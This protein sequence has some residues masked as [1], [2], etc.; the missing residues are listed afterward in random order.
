MLRRVKVGIAV[1]LAL[2]LSALSGAAVAVNGFTDVSPAST[3]AEGIAWANETGLMRGFGDGS[4]RPS[5]P[6]ERGQFAST[7]QSYHSQLQPSGEPG[8][9]GP[10]GDQGPAGPTGP[11][12]PAGEM[13]P[14]Y[15]PFL[16]GVGRTLQ[17]IAPEPSQALSTDWQDTSLR[18]NE[19]PIVGTTSGDF[20]LLVDVAA[21][22]TA[23]GP[24]GNEQDFDTEICVRLYNRSE[25]TH[26]P[27]S[28]VCHDG[29]DT[30]FMESEPFSITGD[31]DIFSL[32]FQGS[33]TPPLEG[34]VRLGTV[35]RGLVFFEPSN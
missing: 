35:S 33:G 20:R 25:Q 24:T 29:R 19:L 5:E 18:P 31:R 14:L 3:H 32:Q 17:A 28:E 11:A 12:G 1:T 2:A 16:Q 30:A 23:F 7:L 22:G 10:A 21:D 9:A 8:P 13:T 4:F 26:V 6:V 15:I 27:G 34:E